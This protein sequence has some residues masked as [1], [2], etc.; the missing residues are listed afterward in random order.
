M[1]ARSHGPRLDHNQENPHAHLHHK[2]PAR[3]GKPSAAAGP[4]PV[5]GGK[6]VL[7]QTAKGGRVLGA[8]DRNGGKTGQQDPSALLFT[9]KPGASTSQ[10][11]A[12]PSCAPRPAQQQFKTPL[13]NKT[14]R[15]QQD[16]R[17]PATALR[18]RHAPPQMLG[19]PDVSM[20]EDVEEQA[21]EPQEEEDR[22]VE[23]AGPSA[24]DYDEPY[25]PDHPEPDYKTAGFGA[26]VKSMPFVAMED[27]ADWAREDAQERSLFKAELDAGMKEHADLASLDSPQPLFPAPKRRAPL[28]SK[29]ANAPSAASAALSR[30]RA[31]STL[32]GSSSTASARKPALGA[33]SAARRPL[34]AS[35]TPASTRRPEMTASSSML[36]G[37]APAPSRLGMSSSK[38]GLSAPSKPLSAAPQRRPLASVSSA[39]SSSAATRPRPP[40]LTLS[41]PASSVSLRSAA[42][43]SS[44]LRSPAQ[45]AAERKAA[46][47]AAERELGIFG[48]VDSEGGDVLEGME[49]AVGAFRFGDEE[50]EFRLEL[51]LALSAPAPT[52]H[53]A[54]ATTT[55]AAVETTQRQDA[56]AEATAPR[57]ATSA[58]DTAPASATSETREGESLGSEPEGGYP[59]QTHAGK[60]GYGPHAPNGGGIADRLK[61]KEEIFKGKLKHD[62]ALLQQGRDRESGVLAERRRAYDAEHDKGAFDKPADG[63]KP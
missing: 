63:E 49:D 50:G 47:Q 33:S 6:G 14:F 11:H 40:P 22:E 56:G 44:A 58:T 38:P 23:Y 12:G 32:G 16:L 34:A 59:E 46:Q 43:G 41:R 2:T 3:A 55:D 18:P 61:A 17:T 10:A 57:A 27:P 5:T 15:P 45:L 13:P 52:E 29:P 31:P 19:S 60:L 20:E 54:P 26:A 53:T 28:A 62:E 9:G 21:H 8:K 37:G 1:L 24:R 7:Q 42:S 25:I 39:S 51:D 36:R 4:A 30:S 48:L 35:G